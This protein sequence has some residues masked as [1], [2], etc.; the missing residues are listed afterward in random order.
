MPAL[1]G[2][3]RVVRTAD[4]ALDDGHAVGGECPCL[5]GADRRRVA[6]RLTRVQMPHQV[7]IRHHLL[8]SPQ[9]QTY[10]QT[11]RQSQHNRRRTVLR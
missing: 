2:V 4:I 6:H 9:P 7:V 11:Y 3:V 10:S 5:V 8:H 1:D